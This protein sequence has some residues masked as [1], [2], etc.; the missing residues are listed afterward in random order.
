MTQPAPAPPAIDRLR[1]VRRWALGVA[2]LAGVGGL[3]D[4]ALGELSGGEGLI[5]IAGGEP[6]GRSVDRA[7]PPFRAETLGGGAPLG[8][9]DFRGKALLVNFWASW[10]APC[11]REA[12]AL[13][14]AWERYRGRGVRF[15]GI[16]YRDDLDAARAFEEELGLTYPS[17]VDP[18]G[19]IG[20]LFGVVAMPSTFLVDPGG[21]IRYQLT[22]VATDGMLGSALDELLGEEG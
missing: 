12:P 6:L 9:A 16:S 8:L 20:A 7:A 3:V 2:V 11:R 4:A 13:E 15:L 1:V 22:G 14:R 17:V 18:D 21:R 19:T 10:C 5:S